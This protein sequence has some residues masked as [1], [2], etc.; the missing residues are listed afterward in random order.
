MAATVGEIGINLWANV[1]A[2][3]SDLAQATG[4]LDR[5]AGD[6]TRSLRSLTGF[7]TSF[8]SAMTG[9]GLAIG[10][11]QFA[12]LVRQA[13][14]AADNIGDLADRAGIGTTQ[15]QAFSFAARSVGVDTEGMVT[16]ITKLNRTL[17]EAAAGNKAAIQSFTDMGVAFQ[18]G[19]AL[20]TTDEVIRSIADRI[21]RAGSVAEQTRIAVEAFGKSGGALVP[22]FRD[23]SKGLDELIARLKEM[24][25]IVD[26]RT[27]KEADDLQ[28]KFDELSS[29]IQT[30]TIKA[31]MALKP[32]LEAAAEWFLRA[33]QAAGRFFD[34]LRAAESVGT[35]E[36]D[37]R[38]AA[39][40]ERLNTQLKIFG[41]QS[42][43]YEVRNAR[44]ELERLQ[45]LRDMG[46]ALEAANEAYTQATEFRPKVEA[47]KPD[48]GALEKT[49]RELEKVNEEARKLGTATLEE[50]DLALDALA[51]KLNASTIEG[52]ALTE[53]TADLSEQ[54]VEFA[55]ATMNLADAMGVLLQKQTALEPSA[56]ELRVQ[57]DAI[58]EEFK[59]LESAIGGLEDLSPLTTQLQLSNTQL[60]AQAEAAKAAA[61]AVAAYES[62][63]SLVMDGVREVFGGVGGAFDGMVQG[64]L[65]G[66]QTVS[67]AFERMGQNIVASLA[68]KAIQRSLKAL[69]DQL[70]KLLEVA[71]RAGLT[72]W[73]GTPT[74][75]APASSGST[76]QS[77]DFSGSLIEPTLFARGGV[78]KRATIGV[79]GESGPE[80][81][82]PLE[83]LDTGGGTTVTVNI[84]DQRKSGNVE[85]R[86]TTNAL[87]EK[88][89]DVLI[90]DVVTQSIGAGAFDRALG[91]SYGLSRR[92]ASR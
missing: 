43:R 65:Q 16:G 52:R 35:E 18:E 66:T 9:V 88:Q 39:A 79:V 73:S 54:S 25:V 47:P 53:S 68:N 56:A 6:A 3:R 42:T 80:A 82:I 92:G 90:T 11:A 77:S 91:Q 14:D 55:G 75:G 48:T 27:L 13:T 12:Q 84:I 61:D 36:L 63:V 45:R 46:S 29:Q 34:R 83:Q 22:I 78:V 64:I 37:R 41:E 30:T 51:L 15:L 49:R 71:V 26:E 59:Q 7:A 89:I 86:E 23:G 8:A 70:I 62:R 81:V 87:G 69:E 4:S 58:T 19:G 44:A 2:L 74:T 85:Q 40:Q 31:I 33:A 28:K 17:G 32:Q 72:A 20:R 38:I 57:W 24:G 21:Q 10:G 76:L 50:L 67:Q 5:F 1:A 60:G